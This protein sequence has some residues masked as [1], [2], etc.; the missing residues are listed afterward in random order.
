MSSTEI[1]VLVVL[2]AF[3]A[4][5]IYMMYSD[6]KK[7]KKQQFKYLPNYEMPQKELMERTDHALAAFGGQKVRGR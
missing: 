5:P 3:V 4:T 2:G 7:R 1:F 6:V